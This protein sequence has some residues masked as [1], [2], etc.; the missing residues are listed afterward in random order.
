[1]NAIEEKELIY[2]AGFFDGEGSVIAKFILHKDYKKTRPYEISL[3]VQYTQATKRRWILEDIKTT[4]GE[5]N[6]RDRPG[7][8]VSDYL[9]V[10]IGPTAR[11]LK[12]LKPYLRLKTKQ[13]SLAIRIAEQLPL[14]KDD[15]EKFYELCYLVDQISALNDNNQRRKNTAAVVIGAMKAAL[16]ETDPVETEE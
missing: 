9:L 2:L 10:G 7:Q 8:K 14:A 16:G 13:A 11:F 5:G 4:I 12:Q 15:N 1:M 3:T 6:V